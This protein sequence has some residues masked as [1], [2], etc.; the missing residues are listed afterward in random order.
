M[1]NSFEQK[2]EN[3]K[4]TERNCVMMIVE[5][6]RG[7]LP[8]WLSYW[9]KS[10]EPN[11]VVYQVTVLSGISAPSSVMESQI[12]P[13]N[14]IQ[15]NCHLK[16]LLSFLF[17]IYLWGRNWELRNGSICSGYWQCRDNKIMRLSTN[18]HQLYILQPEPCLCMPTNNSTTLFA[19]DKAI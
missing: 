5:E 6:V 8:L 16:L 14:K 7:D 9:I 10:R 1:M 12:P 15:L 2:T 11:A 4:I 13:C 19:I 3:D 18:K 17:I